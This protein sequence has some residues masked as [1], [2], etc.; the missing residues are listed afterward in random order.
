MLGNVVP[1]NGTSYKEG[2][3]VS[4]L[5]TATDADG[6]SLTYIWKEGSRELGRGSPFTTSGLKAGKHTVTLVV[7]DG[8]ATV[9]RQLEVVVK[10]KEG[11]VGGAGTIILLVAVIAV[12]AVIVVVAL[13]MRSRKGPPPAEQETAS[14]AG[15]EGAA[16]GQTTTSSEA[17]E[18]PKIE[19][20]HRE[21]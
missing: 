3:A 13:A 1:L 7:D 15:P 14:L 17:E 10:E 19:I 11:G 9:E 4:F 5:A 12:A 21:V 20:E 8:N 16:G 2:E 6:D 18:P